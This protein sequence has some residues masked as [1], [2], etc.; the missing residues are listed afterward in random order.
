MG[1]IAIAQV[2]LGCAVL[3]IVGRWIWS[4]R[5]FRRGYLLALDHVDEMT[6]PGPIQRS[7]SDAIRQLRREMQPARPNE[8]VSEEKS[9]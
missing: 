5:E 1:D 9:R 3:A 6:R 4:S 8:S 2:V 7:T